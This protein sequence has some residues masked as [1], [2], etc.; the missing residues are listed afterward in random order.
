MRWS[1]SSIAIICVGLWHQ[2][3]L[4]ISDIFDACAC[5]QNPPILS[6]FSSLL[7][8]SR[9]L[10]LFWPGRPHRM[11]AI[12][13]Y[14][15]KV[16]DII[17]CIAIYYENVCNWECLHLERKV[18]SQDFKESEDAESFERDCQVCLRAM[19]WI[20]EWTIVFFHWYVDKRKQNS[21]PFTER[22][23]T[24][25]CAYLSAIHWILLWS[26]MWYLF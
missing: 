14:Q 18:L 23:V 8:F 10:G 4:S 2:W 17:N 22:N 13:I 19:S 12:V 3:H 5:N 11:V 15:N 24:I 21:K 26:F 16:F 7:T 25:I 1:L 9:A 20:W 6:S